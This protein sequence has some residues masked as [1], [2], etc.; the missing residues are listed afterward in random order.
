MERWNKKPQ[1]NVTLKQCAC[2]VWLELTYAYGTIV[3]FF[4]LKLLDYKRERNSTIQK[5]FD[6]H[7]FSQPATRRQKKNIFQTTSRSEQ[8]RKIELETGGWGGRWT[9]RNFWSIRGI[10]FLKVYMFC[11]TKWDTDW[12]VSAARDIINFLNHNVEYTLCNSGKKSPVGQGEEEEKEAAMSSKKKKKKRRR[13]LPSPP[14]IKHLLIREKKG[15]CSGSG[16]HI[17]LPPPHPHPPSVSV[18]L[19][20]VAPKER[21]EEKAATTYYVHGEEGTKTVIESAI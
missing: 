16:T 1:L 13:R 10:V 9:R 8:R 3:D 7:F 6:T 19:W 12:D 5:G 14:S 2:Q 20:L 4:S 21:K 18:S 17:V 11:C 15:C